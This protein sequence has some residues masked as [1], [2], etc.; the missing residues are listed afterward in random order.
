MSATPPTLP[1]GR[2]AQNGKP[3]LSR[4]P[5]GIDPLVQRKQPPKYRPPVIKNAVQ[6]VNGQPPP[7]PAMP[8]Q[9]VSK[10]PSPRPTAKPPVKTAP[11]EDVGGFSDPAATSYQ[12]FK[13]VTTKRALLEGLRHHVLSLT[14]NQNYD[15]QNEEDFTRPVRLHRRD[16]KVQAPAPLKEEGEEPPPNDMDKV[17]REA[18]LKRK[19]ERQK[20]REANLAQIAPSVDTGKKMKNFTKKT[21]QV[22]RPG[23]ST[24][25]RLKARDKYEEKLPW[26]LEDFNEKHCLVGS[27]QPTMSHLYAAFVLEADPSKQAAG[28]C[29]ILPIDKW[30]KFG[31]KTVFQTLTIEEAEKQMKKLQKDPEWLERHRELQ[32][33]ERQFERISRESRGLFTAPKGEGTLAG[34][35]AEDGGADLD[36]EDDFADD[37]EGNLFEEKDEDQKL[38]E[39]RIKQEQ[40]SANFFD[41]KDEREVDLQEKRE[42]LLKENQAKYGRKLNKALRRREGNFNIGSDTEDDMFG[43]DVSFD[44]Y[45][46]S[47]DSNPPP[48]RPP[49]IRK[50]NVPR[51]PR[52]KQRPRKRRQANQLLRASQGLRPKEQTLHLVVKKSMAQRVIAILLQGRLPH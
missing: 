17:E 28:R 1:S 13:L 20:E 45:V 7:R 5:V 51:K 9:A 29:R 34:G 35:R 39:Q 11:K 8:T 14:S 49:P 12:D 3:V 21:E 36:F 48:S 16:P 18:Y 44:V 24:D 37:E 25:Q 47:T 15:I 40:L 42:Q 33:K 30:Y 50:L 31:P 6:P 52:K 22:F 10:Q 32:I 23:Q 26:H 43:S 27:Y 38:A 41:N 2:P 4:K 46:L 19:E